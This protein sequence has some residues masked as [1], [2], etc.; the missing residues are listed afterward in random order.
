MVAEAS[1]ASRLRD[2]LEVKDGTMKGQLHA[3]YTVV[4]NTTSHDALEKGRTATSDTK[5][6]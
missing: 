4:L 2:L 5:I 6:R 1:D 3:N